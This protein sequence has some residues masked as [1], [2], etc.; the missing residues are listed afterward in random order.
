VTFTDID[1][2]VQL[3]NVVFTTIAISDPTVPHLAS[4]QQCVS[5]STG[6]ASITVRATY[7]TGYHED[8]TMTY[9]NGSEE[10]ALTT[11]GSPVAGLLWQPNTKYII[12]LVGR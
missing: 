2:T 6:T 11:S 8:L 10:S 12:I 5:F 9:R 7:S 1:Q 3:A 4:G